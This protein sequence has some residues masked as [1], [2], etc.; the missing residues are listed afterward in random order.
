MLPFIL[1][2]QNWQVHRDRKEIGG[3]QGPEGLKSWERL[4]TGMGFLLGVVERLWNEKVRMLTQH[5]EYTTSSPYRIIHL[6]M[7]KLATQHFVGLR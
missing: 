1:S 2:A 4:L 7:V 6:I 5:C 3:C